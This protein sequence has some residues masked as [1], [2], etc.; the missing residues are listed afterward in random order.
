VDHQNQAPAALLALGTAV[1]PYQA[2][3]E[4]IAQWMITSLAPRPSLERLVRGLYGSSGIDQRYSCIDDFLSPPERSRFAPGQALEQISTTAER[5]AIYEQAAPCLA[6]NAARE[7]LAQ[8]ADQETASLALVT[9]S[10]T[11]LIVVTCTGF[12]A[13]GLDLALARQL[14]LAPSVERTVVGFMGCSAAFNALRMADHIVRSRPSARVLV[15]CVELC[16]LHIQPGAGRE[17][18]IAGSLFADGAA[19][20]VVGSA[21]SACGDIFC[22]DGFYSE[23]KPATDGDMVWQIG[24]HGFALRLSPQVPKHLATIAPDALRR[25]CQPDHPTEE[26]GFWAI[27]PG[28]PA[29]VDR[30]AA[31]F[32]L[33]PDQIEATRSVLRR[34]GNMSS[35]TILF[36]LAEVLTRL[37][38]GGQCQTGVAMAFGPGLVIEMARLT[39]L[40]ATNNKL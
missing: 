7:A 17:D 12:F 37:Q 32:A 39:Y 6:T 26:L 19:A 10:I 18:L 36:V 20:C 27:H 3:Q 5:M 22:L 30:L 1:P 9:A 25:L 8:L 31:V 23:V 15:V 40:P 28:G 13:P 16:S 35:G 4:E 21:R 11:H 29:I 24:N 33:A 2:R 14:N 38:S 34:Y